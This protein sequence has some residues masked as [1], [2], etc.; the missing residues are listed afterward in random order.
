[1]E[2]QRAL[3]FVSVAKLSRPRFYMIKYANERLQP[4]LAQKT[5][6]LHCRFERLYENKLGAFSSPFFSNF[7]GFWFIILQNELNT[8]Q[9]FW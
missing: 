1:M 3:E 7:F 2:A 8:M 5:N 6:L 4:R 9:K